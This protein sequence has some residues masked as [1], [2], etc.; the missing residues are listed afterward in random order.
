M[1]QNT[2]YHK[3]G[4]VLLSLGFADLIIGLVVML[5]QIFT[6]SYDAMQTGDTLGSIT[7]F[8]YAIPFMVG[9]LICNGLGKHFWNRTEH[10][11]SSQNI[12]A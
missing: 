12:A 2:F 10:V 4:T 8:L 9:A 6:V 1:K 5:Y 11:A 7:A 3:L